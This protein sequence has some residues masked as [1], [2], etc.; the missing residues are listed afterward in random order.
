MG[1]R[2]VF[3]VVM[4]FAVAFGVPFV[5]AQSADTEHPTEEAPK[6]GAKPK[7]KGTGQPEAE[8]LPDVGSAPAV[9]PGPAPGAAPEKDDL[10]PPAA[11]PPVGAL[12]APEEAGSAPAAP[13][14][15]DPKVEP[16]QAPPATAAPQSAPPQAADPEN[17]LPV[18]IGSKPANPAAA[19]G[20]ASDAE[21]FVLPADKLEADHQSVG[22]MIEVLGPQKVNLN[23]PALYKI[24]VK[25]TGS[26]D[27]L[28]VAVRDEL[29]PNLEFVSSQPAEERASESLLVWRLGTIQAGQ[30]RV[31]TLNVKPTK[32]GDYHHAATVTMMAGAKSRTV[33]QEPKLRVEQMATTGNILKGHQ[34]TFKIR[35]TNPG[36]GVARNVVVRAKLSAG[37]RATVDEPN[38]LNLFQIALGDLGPGKSVDLD[39]LVAD[40]T[41]GGQ[42]TCQVT[43]VSKDVVPDQEGSQS[44]QTVTVVEPG[45]ELAFTGDRERFT[46]Q[47]ASYSISLKNPGTAAA[48]NVKLGITI[49]VNA[50]PVG[51]LPSGMSWNGNGRRLTWSIAELQPGDKDMVTLPFQVR[52]GGPGFVHIAAEAKADG[53]LSRPATCQ[54][55][56]QGIAVLEMDVETDRRVIDVDDDARYQIKITNVGTK[57]ASNILVR[58]KISDNLNV[59]ETIGTDE[60]A[61]FSPAEH[62]VIFPAIPHLAA[63]SSMTLGI[64]VKAAKAGQGSCRVFLINDNELE[65][66]I[67]QLATTRITG[68]RRQ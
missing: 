58:A 48:R 42:Q 38:R 25:N 29:P 32:V 66:K 61:K 44:T 20:A 4:A 53:G 52:V 62:E 59:K 19:P 68:S 22:L 67:E 24:V 8:P 3:F 55:Q 64:R 7:A 54:T 34:A 27:A 43:A 2:L 56:V 5:L 41:R 49:P 16:A 21:S 15:L 65:N 26:S 31:I 35:V 37:L 23:K 14:T 39:P 63:K 33:V 18:A 51:T 9:D 12:P 45:L 6:A 50:T 36:S 10:A 47:V 60:A 46:D 11:M 57:E 28:R 17:P 30:E 40:T 13:A 1:R